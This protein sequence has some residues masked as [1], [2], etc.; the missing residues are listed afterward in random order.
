MNDLA[1]QAEISRPTLYSVFSSKE[2]VARAVIQAIADRNIAATEAELPTVQG[3]SNKLDVAFK[4]SQ[5]ALYKLIRSSPHADDVL[6]GFN[7]AAKEEIAKGNERFRALVENLLTTHESEVRS[8]GIS[9]KKLADFI[10]NSA[11]GYKNRA[12]NMAHLKELLDSLKALVLSSEGH[13]ASSGARPH[14]VQ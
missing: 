9:H 12:K 13:D 2:D 5:V 3:L 1:V 14:R 8:V 4:H 7:A 10:Q 11:S 6:S